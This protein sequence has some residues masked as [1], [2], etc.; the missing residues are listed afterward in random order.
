MPAS[1]EGVVPPSAPM[2]PPPQEPLVDPPEITQGRPVQQSAVVVQPPAL[3]THDAP[4]RRGAPPSVTFV[5]THASPQQSALLEQTRPALVPASAQLPTP[6]Q[7]GI[8]T[9]SCWQ[10]VGSLFT[11]PAQQLF[12]ALQ[13]VEASLQMAP[14]ARHEPPLLQRPIDSPA[15]MLH[16]TKAFIFPPGSSTEPQ[17][18]LSERQRSPVGWH[19]LG[20]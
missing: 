11:F 16:V 2:P 14:A 6:V 1:V 15:A 4:H 8:P 3:G 17:Q 19:P 12:S 13:E 20:A 9:M 10:T 18:S 5:G 7:R